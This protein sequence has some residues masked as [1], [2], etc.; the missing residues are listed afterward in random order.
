MGGFVRKQGRA[1]LGGKVANNGV[2]EEGG[3]A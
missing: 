1:G 2:D 3:A